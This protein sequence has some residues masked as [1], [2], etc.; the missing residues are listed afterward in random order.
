M[1]ASFMQINTDNQVLEEALKAFETQAMNFAIRFIKDSKVRFQYMDKTKALSNEYLLK[2]QRGQ[3]TACQAANEVN[4]LRNEIMELA[5]LRS[6][7]IGKARAESLKKTGKTL[8]GLCEHYAKK[9]FCKDFVNLTKVQQNEVY[10]E[11]IK[12]AGNE[13]VVIGGGFVG[14]A[15]GG[16][17]AGCACGPGAP[18]CVTIGV[19]VG[20]LLGAFGADFAFDSIF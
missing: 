9:K 12:A 11:I 7:D 16:G 8:E 2:V 15:I 5:R 17:V 4:L 20:G 14:G 13:G 10:K 3:L 1:N 19:F 18:V 6:S